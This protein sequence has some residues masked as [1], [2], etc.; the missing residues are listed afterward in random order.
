MFGLCSGSRGC[1]L[2]DLTLANVKDDGK[3]LVVQIPDTKTKVAKLYV[4]GSEFTKIIRKYLDMRPRHVKTDRLFLQWR[5]GKCIAQVM[6]KHSIAQIPKNVARFLNLP[7]PD[8]YTGHSYR[9]TTT[10]VAANAGFTVTELKRLMG[11]K[12][13]RVCEG[14]IQ[15][16]VAYQRSLS[17]RVYDAILPSTSVEKAADNAPPSSEGATPYAPSTIPAVTPL[18][19]PTVV[20]SPIPAVVHSSIPAVVHSSIP[21]V[22]HSSIPAV[23]PSAVVPSTIS[24]AIPTLQERDKA[25]SVTFNSTSGL[26]ISDGGKS[27]TI[28]GAVGSQ[29]ASNKEPNIIF[30][31]GGDNNSFT[32]INMK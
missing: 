16:S 26:T 20:T 10:T 1:E 18:S 21:P 15:N 2:T 17:K 32:I 19:I 29:N 5:K 14:Y 3:E 12:S 23:V 13:D 4:V 27:I 9:R 11:W 28:S 24:G 8:S 7:D 22:V 6:G 25:M 31:F 30:H